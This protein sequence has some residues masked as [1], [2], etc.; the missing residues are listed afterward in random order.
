MK[1]YGEKSSLEGFMY[2]DKVT[3]GGDKDFID[4]KKGTQIDPPA[5]RTL[6]MGVGCTVKETA[7]FKTQKPNGILGLSSISNSSFD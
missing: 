6:E 2:K 1:D 7:M 4:T 3:L 5:S